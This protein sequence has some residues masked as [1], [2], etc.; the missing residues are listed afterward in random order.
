MMSAV[1][2]ISFE[3]CPNAAKTKLALEELGVD[4]DEIRQDDLASDSP[5]KN[6][7]SPTI[8][9]DDKVIFGIATGGGGGCSLVVPTADDLRAKLGLK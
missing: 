2:F 5:F 4:F 3:G 7:A 1:K 9:K 6:Y 8:L